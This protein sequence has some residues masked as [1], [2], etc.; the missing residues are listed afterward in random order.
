MKKT[1][2]NLSIYKQSVKNYKEINKKFLEY[3]DEIPQEESYDKSYKVNKADFKKSQDFNRNYIS[4]FFS[5]FSPYITNIAK[6]LQCKKSTV[7]NLW[8]QQY[9]KKD[10]HPWHNHAKSNYTGIYFVELPEKL[11]TEFLNITIDEL[12]EG[13]LLIFP[14]SIMH[15][16]P[17]NTTDKRKTIISFNMDYEDYEGSLTITST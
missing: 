11:G 4:H 6:E 7:S 2:I 3:F 10:Y 17:V 1:N 9:Q 8:F 12:N 16:S 13:D 15:R 5:E 14:S